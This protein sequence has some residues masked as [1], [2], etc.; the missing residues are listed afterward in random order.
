MD[1]T[2]K[3]FLI[4]NSDFYLYTC[5]F[6][7]ALEYY[8]WSIDKILSSE[9]YN[10]IIGIREK[11]AVGKNFI[12]NFINN[13]KQH[14][15]KIQFLEEN[16]LC[17]PE[18]QELSVEIFRREC[19][20]K[21]VEIITPTINTENKKDKIKLQKWFLDPNTPKLLRTALCGQDKFRE[22]PTI[23]LINRK[24]TRKLIN[25]KAIIDN[26]KKINFNV[27]EVFFEDKS[28][29]FQINFCNTHDI[30]ISPHGANLSSTPFM[31]DYS[32]VMEI[33]NGEWIP[34]NYYAGLSISSNKSHCILCENHPF[35]KWQTNT[36]CKQQKL[37][38]FI[39]PKK[40]INTIK[41]FLVYRSK[42]YKESSPDK[43]L[44]QLR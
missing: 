40:V 34:Y 32:L 36:S 41:E 20:Y 42:I 31:Q 11:H 27:E 2:N 30:I 43:V 37:D 25:S 18:N 21:N 5:H 8:Y 17:P 15:P 26:I 3:N 29:E 35:P 13:I 44:F 22:I 16:N 28:F 33:A 19:F 39:E 14:F 9:N 10:Y 12:S 4:V 23:G 6:A 24:N 7:H 38:I 1:I